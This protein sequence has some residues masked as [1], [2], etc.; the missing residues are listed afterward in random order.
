MGH[1]K[2]RKKFHVRIVEDSV[3]CIESDNIIKLLKGSE[4]SFVKAKSHAEKT[5]IKVGFL[6]ISNIKRVRICF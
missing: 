5:V 1:Q 4:I 2:D 3:V 6:E